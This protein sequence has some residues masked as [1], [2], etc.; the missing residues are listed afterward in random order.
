MTDHTEIPTDVMEAVTFAIQEVDDLYAINLHTVEEK[1]IIARVVAYVEPLIARAILAERERCARI[2][3]DAA[4][5]AGSAIL[6]SG[7]AWAIV[8]SHKELAAKEIAS[9]IR[10]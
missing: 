1:E 4:N 6:G 8:H 10:K 9:A 3:E 7:D 5:K 2:S